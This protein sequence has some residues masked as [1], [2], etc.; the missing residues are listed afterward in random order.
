LRFRLSLTQ[1]LKLNIKLLVYLLRQSY[2]SDAFD[3]ENKM[4]KSNQQP[5]IKSALSLIN[6]KRL[7][8]IVTTSLLMIGTNVN[9]QSTQRDN[10]DQLP[11]LSITLMILVN[12]Y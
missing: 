7:L 5:F 9:S 4:Y 1:T 8:V 2:K 6:K 12:A 10:Y 11:D 3:I